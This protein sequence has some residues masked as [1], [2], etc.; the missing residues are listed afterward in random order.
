MTK[1]IYLLS[2][3][4]LQPDGDYFNAGWSTHVMP[5]KGD[6][7]QIGRD[8]WW[9]VEQV[10]IHSYHSELDAQLV[11]ERVETQAFPL[12]KNPTRGMRPDFE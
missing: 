10:I 6:I 1:P 8:A 2:L 5:T 9:K 7:L 12:S 11:L 3:H 4:L